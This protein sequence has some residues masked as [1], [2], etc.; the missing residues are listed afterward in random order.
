MV[1]FGEDLSYGCSIELT[2]TDLESGCGSLALSGYE[3]FKN[4]EK[5]DQ[6]GRF[7]SANFNYIKVSTFLYSDCLCRTGRASLWIKN[8]WTS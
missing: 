7:G 6:V 1:T 8:P 4:L 2:A 5:V 3:I